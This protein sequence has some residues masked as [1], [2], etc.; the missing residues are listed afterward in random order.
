V[1]TIAHSAAT[2]SAPIAA[3]VAALDVYHDAD[4]ITACA[5]AA[6]AYDGAR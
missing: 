6:A 1:L 5:A 4:Y 3:R 2:A